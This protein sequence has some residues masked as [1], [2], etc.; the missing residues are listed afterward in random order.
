M[1]KKFLRII[2]S[3][4]LI[5]TLILPTVANATYY[6]I[7]LGDCNYD[8]QVDIIDVVA[9]RSYII[10]N[11]LHHIDSF[12]FSKAA[13]LNEDSNIDIVDV[14][15]IRNIIVGN[16]D[17]HV[18]EARIQMYAETEVNGH[19]AVSS[20]SP[21]AIPG[22]SRD[23]NHN[24]TLNNATLYVD[25]GNDGIFCDDDLEI[26]LIGDSQIILSDPS[27]TGI[28]CYG[29]LRITGDGTL[30]IKGGYAGIISMHNIRI[31]R[32][33]TVNIE[34]CGYGIDALG[35]IDLYI[36]DINISNAF[37]GISTA[38][39]LNV[40]L[41]HLNINAYYPITT[42]LESEFESSN[43]K[44]NGVMGIISV[45]PIKIILSN[46]DIHASEE[47]NTFGEENP[48]GASVGICSNSSVRLERVNGTIEGEYT[49]IYIES[50]DYQYT[51]LNMDYERVNENYKYKTNS[52]NTDDGTY[53]YVVI[54]NG[55][56]T[57]S[58]DEITNLVTKLEIVSPY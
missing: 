44:L 51:Y 25:A 38:E 36:C 23:G 34:D 39:S 45:N 4:T 29:N 6:Y 14:A 35:N 54:T 31:G 15:M 43:L 53:R 50:L 42:V 47:H 2:I 37:Y 8:N 24:L 20:S 57:Y 16:A 30:T 58:G 5:A 52:Y 9:I 18:I 40:Y 48:F 10:G 13:D 33:S 22:I 41:S 28:K 21:D 26:K 12:V 11:P 56:P 46:V 32:D 49:A 1:Y 27:S 19:V 17:T 7:Y 3:L 55:E